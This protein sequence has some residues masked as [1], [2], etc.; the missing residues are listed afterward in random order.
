[1][2]GTWTTKN[3]AHPAETAEELRIGERPDVV[4]EAREDL[5]RR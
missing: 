4:V 1:M 5:R 3:S 2:I